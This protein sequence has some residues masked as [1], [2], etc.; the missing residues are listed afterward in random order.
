MLSIRSRQTGQVGS[1]TR[2]EVGGGKGRK[3]SADEASVLMVGAIFGIKG[4]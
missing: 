4:S 3:S 2:E 1:S